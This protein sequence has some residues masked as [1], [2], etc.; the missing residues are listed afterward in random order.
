MLRPTGTSTRLLKRGSPSSAA[1]FRRALQ[2]GGRGGGGGF[3]GCF[4]PCV[5]PSG[6]ASFGGPRIQFAASAIFFT[7]YKAAKIGSLAL[8]TAATTS[9]R[10]VAL[11]VLTE[12]LVLLGWRIRIGNWRCH[13]RGSDG[14]LVSLLERVKR[15]K[16]RK[17]AGSR[18]WNR[19]KRLDSFEP[20]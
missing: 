6:L 8:L 12:Y 13:R 15:G 19:E 11:L 10:Y 7:A 3:V 9:I 14:V 17:D 2:G 16:V 18:I 20:R 5:G 4:G 1:T